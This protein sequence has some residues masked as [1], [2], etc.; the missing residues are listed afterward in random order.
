VADFESAY[1]VVALGVAVVLVV[2]GGIAIVR[3][4]RPLMLV[5]II[6][7]MAVPAIAFFVFALGQD[8]ATEP[9]ALTW[10]AFIP[11][12][13]GLAAGVGMLVLMRTSKAYSRATLD[14]LANGTA[15][16]WG[17]I[18]LGLT[19]VVYLFEPAF[20]IANLALN[21]AWVVLWV[22]RRLRTLRTM[23]SLEVHAPADRVYGFMVDPAN[24]KL[25]QDDVESVTV[26]PVG[27]LA[28]ASRVTVRRRI[29]PGPLRGPRFGPYAV[30]TASVITE[31]VLGR[32]IASQEVDRPAA[33]A[34]TELQE[35]GGGTLVTSIGQGLMPFR[36]ALFGGMVEFWSRR[37]EREAAVRRRRERLISL[38]D[39][40]QESD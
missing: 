6:L 31:L 37:R 8:P 24:W 11:V 2:L 21:A 35:H 14:L 34:R 17:G 7:L 10:L 5:P 16:V 4:P 22:P 33:Q 38:L 9:T 15:V 20:A 12:L 23:F 30:E 36:Y 18:V 19:D 26:V 27:A 32:L 13:A 29:D 25:Y 28:I 3:Y 1:R 39:R 40:S